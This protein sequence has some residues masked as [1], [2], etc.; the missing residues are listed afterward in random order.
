MVRLLLV[1]KI[2]KFKAV[3]YPDSNK[4]RAENVKG[5]LKRLFGIFRCDFTCAFNSWVYSNGDVIQ[6]PAYKWISA[7]HLSKP[8]L[9]GFLVD[10]HP[11][12][13]HPTVTTAC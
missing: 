13:M 12:H 10:K 3:S 1:T 8:Y 11:H 5:G 9:G 2:M 4:L 7:C 6:Q